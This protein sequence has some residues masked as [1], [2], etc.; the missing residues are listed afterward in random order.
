VC[1]GSGLHSWAFSLRCFAEIYA[2]KFGVSPD[3]MVKKLWGDHYYNPNSKKWQTTPDTPDGLPLRRAFVQFILDPLYKLFDAI[4][5]DEVEKYDKMLK[6]LAIILTEEERRIPK[7]PLL[8]YAMRKFLPISEA[9]LEMIVM[10][11]PS[12]I[13]AQKYRV[14]NLYD[15]PLDD[16]CAEAIRNC[17]PK[18]PLMIYVSRMVPST[19]KGRFY[20]FGR[21]F[22]GTV[23]TGQKVRIMGQDYVPGK[24]R[25]LFVKNIQRL[26][27]ML[28]QNIEDVE[29]GPAGNLIGISGIDQFLIKT[30]TISTSEQAIPFRQFK[31]SV[32]P[33]YRVVVECK[34]PSDLP[35]IR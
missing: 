8:K 3:R 26:V 31:Y 33:V 11:L 5:N 22:S 30:G 24:T 32:A 7:R 12:P 23:S 20:A 25:D 6:S 27:L 17:D 1:F 13:K 18:G 21:V 19:D 2:K 10:H 15:G 9:V 28:G 35:K 14:Q 34:N 4:M 29:D 16:E